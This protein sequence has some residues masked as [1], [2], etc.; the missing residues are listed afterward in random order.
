MSN[1]FIRILIS[2]LFIPIILAVCL[3]G[4][5]FF[6]GFALVIGA[7]A[8]YEFISMVKKKDVTGSLIVGLP[9]VLLLI[10]N[11]YFNFIDFLI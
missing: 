7:L 11:A 4:K 9:A 8:Y 2:V 1:T 3:L 10:L 6:L 5:F